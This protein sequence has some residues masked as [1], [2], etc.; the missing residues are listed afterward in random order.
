MIENCKTIAKEDKRRIA[1]LLQLAEPIEQ[2][3]KLYKDHQ[4]EITEKY[5]NFNFEDGADAENFTPD[6]NNVSLNKN[7]QKKKTLL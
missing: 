3:I 4:P 5:S 7:F 1:Q 6:P 2:T